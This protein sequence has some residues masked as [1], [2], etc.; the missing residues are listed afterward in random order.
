MHGSASLLT[1]DFVGGAVAVLATRFP[2]TASVAAFLLAV[3]IEGIGLAL[4]AT[5]GILFMLIL[6]KRW[7]GWFA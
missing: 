6:T 5:L 4:L 3:H 2:I 1:V 7:H